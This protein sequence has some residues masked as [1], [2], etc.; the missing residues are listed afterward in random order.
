MKLKSQIQNPQFFSGRSAARKGIRARYFVQRSSCDGYEHEKSKEA[1]E[2]RAK[3][4]AKFKVI[5]VLAWDGPHSGESGTPATPRHPQTGD[6]Q[7]PTPRMAARVFP[8][9]P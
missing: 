2:I 5:E 8:Q 3:A 1:I 4:F 9:T 7:G 6:L